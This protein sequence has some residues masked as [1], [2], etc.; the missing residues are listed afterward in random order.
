[1]RRLRS[2][3]LGHNFAAA[4]AGAPADAKLDPQPL[5]ALR[6][7]ASRVERL[8]C[9]NR[10]PFGSALWKQSAFPA[11]AVAQLRKAPSS[12][13]TESCAPKTDTPSTYE[14]HQRGRFADCPRKT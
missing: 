1:V 3:P 7:V 2:R 10:G 4:G 9:P 13:T 14:D 5:F 12:L 11:S 6:R 8:G